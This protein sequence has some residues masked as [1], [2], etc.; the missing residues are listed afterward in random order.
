MRYDGYRWSQR[1]LLHHGE[2]PITL[3]DAL[4][5][6]Q[7]GAA[8]IVRTSVEMIGACVTGL[9]EKD[10]R[11]AVV[12]RE[13]LVHNWTWPL[14]VKNGG[15]LL[16]LMLSLCPTLPRDE[17][18]L[19][20]W[21]PE[22][23]SAEVAEWARRWLDKNAINENVVDRMKQT[24]RLTPMV[25]DVR[26]GLPYRC[27]VTPALA[28]LYLLEREVKENQQRTFIAI[29]TCKEHTKLVESWRD[30]PKSKRTTIHSPITH[31]RLEL[32]L[33]DSHEKRHLQ[34]SLALPD[35]PLASQVSSALREWR[36]WVGLRHWVAFQSQITVN[37]RLGWVRWTVE[38]HLKAMG[39]RKDRRR[40][41]ELRRAA[42]EM[43]ELFTQIELG[44]YDD[45]GK[46]R[47]RRPLVLKG[48]TY[49]RLVG[50][51]WEIEGLEL[52]INPLLYRGV[53][54]PETGKLGSNWWPTPKE[55]P[56]IDHQNY[57]PAIALG[58]VLPARWR[59][60]IVQSNKSYI[61]LKGDSLL[62]AAGLPYRQRNVVAT[63]RSV[64]RNLTELQRRGGLEE[65]QWQGSPDLST[66]CRL[67]APTWAVD[68]IAHG[69]PPKENKPSPA[70]LTGSELKSWR[71]KEGLTQRGAAQM[72]GVGESTIR[73][74]ERNPTRPLSKNL[75][76]ALSSLT[77]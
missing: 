43:I 18:L 56:H 55:L 26:A 13:R 73:R 9:V 61:D 70:A 11:T 65:W 24:R 42:A 38:E 36:S 41:L 45:K 74:A 4:A 33:P 20:A 21:P 59:M 8:E 64:E 34:L 16:H 48:N 62:R 1:Q 2:G 17:P 57:G 46:I 77:T 67:Y 52:K 14:G 15:A 30:L 76:E 58:T 32:I 6:I 68:R 69:V 27:M 23:A 50:S 72:L 25:F 40:R 35:E 3:A 49:E 51:E 47:E 54:D 10:A 60:E 39:Y 28:L 29:D 71:K 75:R 5:R 63:W 53:R 31:G 22:A 12:S 66:V 37:Q 7:D 19:A 44:I